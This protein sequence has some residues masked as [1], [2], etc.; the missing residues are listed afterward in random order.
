MCLGIAGQVASMDATHP[1]LVS[2]DVQGVRRDINIGLLPDP[3]AVGDWIL[4]HL[5]FALQ[6][7]TPEEAVDSLDVLRDLGQGEEEHIDDLGGQRY[8][9]DDDE[10][11][12]PALTLAE[13][14]R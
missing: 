4:I 2:V 5:G 14:E 12:A 1:D 6:T 3:V 10:A 7:M 9:W 8:P 11:P 13:V